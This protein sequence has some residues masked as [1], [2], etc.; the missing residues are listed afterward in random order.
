MCPEGSV[1]GARAVCGTET[2]GH[3]A[4]DTG[5]Q[6]RDD[7]LAVL[8]TPTRT[9]G[10]FSRTTRRLIAFSSPRICR[11]NNARKYSLLSA[12]FSSASSKE[13]VSITP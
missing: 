11:S 10:K 8:R 5:M 12:S 1:Q 2:L 7:V 9:S 3:I 4:V 6:C 13:P